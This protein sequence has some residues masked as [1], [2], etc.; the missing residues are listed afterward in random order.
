MGKYLRSRMKHTIWGNK[1]NTVVNSIF[2]LFMAVIIQWPIKWI[3]AG[4]VGSAVSDT[5]AVSEQQYLGF[6]GFLHQHDEEPNPITG[7]FPGTTFLKPQMCCDT[8]VLRSVTHRKVQKPPGEETSCFTWKYQFVSTDTLENV[9]RS[10]SL[11]DMNASSDTFNMNV[12][13]N[14]QI[15]AFM[16]LLKHKMATFHFGDW[17]CLNLS[18]IQRLDRHL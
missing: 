8:A 9:L 10:G 16:L 7:M 18:V 11:S 2:F 4:R 6:T 1:F 15:W 13:W 14:V 12:T 17:K 5:P 3:S